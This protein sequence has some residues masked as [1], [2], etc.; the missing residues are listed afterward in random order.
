M[1]ATRVPGCPGL[2][3]SWWDKIT[4][5]HATRGRRVYLRS[6]SP[7]TS[8]SWEAKVT[9]PKN[10]IDVCQAHSTLSSPTLPQSPPSSAF[11]PSSGSVPPGLHTQ[12]SLCSVSA[13]PQGPIAWMKLSLQN[14]CQ[15]ACS[16]RA[17]ILQIIVIGT[18][19]MTGGSSQ[20]ERGILL[21]TTIPWPTDLRTSPE[22]LHLTFYAGFSL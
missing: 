4:W 12:V 15:A 6:E 10:A 13:L 5:Q 18:D 9:G 19:G 20:E 2:L 11:P 16:L 1:T 8:H 17:C 21:I 14:T 7:G 22:S 3:S